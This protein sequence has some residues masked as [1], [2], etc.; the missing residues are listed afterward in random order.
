MTLKLSHPH[1]F[2]MFYYLGAFEVINLIPA[3]WKH[4]VIIY[5]CIVTYSFLQCS[6]IGDFIL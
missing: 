6:S 5:D 2:T 4:S 1:D 3:Q